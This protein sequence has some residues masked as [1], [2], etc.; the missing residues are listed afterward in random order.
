MELHIYETPTDYPI[1]TPDHE[2]Y[3]EEAFRANGYPEAEIAQF[4]REIETLDI[5]RIEDFTNWL[6][7]RESGTL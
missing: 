2:A 4:R 5:D 6:A 7:A 1:W 3:I